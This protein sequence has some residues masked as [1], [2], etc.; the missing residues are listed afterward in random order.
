MKH[1]PFERNNSVGIKPKNPFLVRCDV[2]LLKHALTKAEAEL[3]TRIVTGFNLVNIEPAVKYI[4]EAKNIVIIVLQENC[5]SDEIMFP[6]ADILH[7]AYKNA[8]LPEILAIWER[9]LDFI[10]DMPIPYRIV[11]SESL[12]PIGTIVPKKE[13]DPCA[14]CGKS[15]WEE[16]N[17]KMFFTMPPYP[18]VDEI[19]PR[20]GGYASSGGAK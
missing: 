8:P 2:I 19:C 14:N 11:E 1:D 12:S 15:G 18:G 16:I 10:A 9:A 17:G 3:Q 4:R 5:F 6:V 7:N 13:V 20:C